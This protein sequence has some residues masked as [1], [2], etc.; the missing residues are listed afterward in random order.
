MNSENGEVSEQ[1]NFTYYQNGKLLWADYSGEDILKGSLIG[2]V[3]I[4]GDLEKI[5]LSEKWEWTSGDYSEGES[6]LVEV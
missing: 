3:S 2:T 1:T 4:N 5:E 6:L